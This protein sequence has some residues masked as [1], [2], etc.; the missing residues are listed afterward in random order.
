MSLKILCLDLSKTKF[1]EVYKKENCPLV[2][3]VRK[4]AHRKDFDVCHDLMTKEEN[5]RIYTFA[6]KRMKKREG[7]LNYEKDWPIG[8]DIDA[9]PSGAVLTVEA[10]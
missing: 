3:K 6:E 8:F 10:E 5:D 4:G 9:L 2:F 7:H 1:A